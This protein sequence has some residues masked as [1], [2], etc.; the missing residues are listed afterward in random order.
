MAGQEGRVDQAVVPVL[1]AA[2]QSLQSQPRAEAAADAPADAVSIPRLW[3]AALLLLASI[4]WLG[5]R[6]A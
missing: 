6:L 2:W 1:D 3:L 4:L 5:W